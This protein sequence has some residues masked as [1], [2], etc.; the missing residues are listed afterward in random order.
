MEQIMTKIKKTTTII[1]SS[2]TSVFLLAMTFLVLYQVF[3]RYILNNPS[4]FTEEIVR[5]LLVW[6]GFIGAAYSFNTRRHMAIVFFQDKLN[7]TIKKYLVAFT[8]LVILLFALF[9]MV[10]G[11][12]NLSLSTMGALSALLNI[13]RGLVYLI[14]P[15]SGIFII[16]GQVIN[17]WED[18]T[19]NIIN[20]GEDL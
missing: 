6:T 12:F 11:G 14:G 4:E 9:I 19:G 7:P 20:I 15:I 1:L 18:L 17:I 13:P 10:I 5:Y 8:N 16:I 3:T 2:I